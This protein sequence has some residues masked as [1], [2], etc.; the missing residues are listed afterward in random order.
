MHPSCLI[1]GLGLCLCNSLDKYH[2]PKTA[3]RLRFPRGV[4]LKII[5]YLT[6]LYL[7]SWQLPFSAELASAWVEGRRRNNMMQHPAPCEAV[8]RL[9]CLA[10]FQSRLRFA[11]GASEQRDCN[12]KL[13]FTHLQAP[14]V[15]GRQMKLRVEK[16]KRRG[17][18]QTPSVVWFNFFFP[19]PPFQKKKKWPFVAFEESPEGSE[20]VSADKR[21]WACG[22]SLEWSR[23]TGA[24]MYGHSC[25]IVKTLP[26]NIGYAETAYHSVFWNVSPNVLCIY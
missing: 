19:L 11:C 15:D 5:K 13:V 24:R 10:D 2:P 25:T 18:G 12:V 7:V 23:M 16:L 3:K 9:N 26:L 4:W 21:S 6:F 20:S 17:G 14:V 22:H 1:S 8:W